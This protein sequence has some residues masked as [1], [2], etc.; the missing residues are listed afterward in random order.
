MLLQGKMILEVRRFTGQEKGDLLLP[1]NTDVNTETLVAYVF[2]SK[3]P[4]CTLP[5]L[6]EFNPYVFSPNIINLDTTSNIVNQGS[7]KM[8]GAVGP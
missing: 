4:N 2:F 8:K 7:K 6:E 1:T 5:A 3:H